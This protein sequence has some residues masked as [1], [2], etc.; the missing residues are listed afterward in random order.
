MVQ[1]HNFLFFITS[2]VVPRPYYWNGSSVEMF[3]LVP[4][5][6]MGL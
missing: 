5:F 1:L 2:M 3:P 4:L 6:P